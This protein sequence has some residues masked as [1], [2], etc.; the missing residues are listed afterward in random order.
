MIKSPD[1]TD[2]LVASFDKTDA[3][4]ESGEVAG[5]NHRLY[6]YQSGMTRCVACLKT[7]EADEDPKDTPCNEKK[8]G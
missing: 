6:H 7:F 8:N 5:S 3:V 4:R 1:K 2:A